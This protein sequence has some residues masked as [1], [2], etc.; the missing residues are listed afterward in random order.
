MQRLKYFLNFVSII[1]FFTVISFLEDFSLFLGV[2]FTFLHIILIFQY[3]CKRNCDLFSPIILY[4]L[5]NILVPLSELYLLFTFNEN[6]FLNA[7]SLSKDFNYLFNLT[8]G[9]NLGAYIFCLIGHKI[10]CKIRINP[11]SFQMPK[12]DYLMIIKFFIFLGLLNFFYNQFYVCSFNFTSIASLYLNVDVIE[13]NSST[14][15]YNLIYLSLYIYLTCINYDKKKKNILLFLCVI[16]AFTT[17]RLFFTL[18]IILVTIAYSYETNESNNKN[19]KFLLLLFLLALL[20]ITLYIIRVSFTYSLQDL[21]FSITDFFKQ[22]GYYA[23]NKGNTPNIAI[24]M[25]L[26]DKWTDFL[27]GKSFLSP[28][29]YFF[30]KSIDFTEFIPAA[31]MKKYYFMA[32]PSGNLPVTGV[33]ELFMNFGYFGVFIGMFIFGGVLRIFYNLFFFSKNNFIKLLGC[34]YSISFFML[35]SKGEVNNIDLFILFEFISFIIFVE[36]LCIAIKN[37]VKRGCL[38]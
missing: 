27:Y 34:Y 38:C 19:K 14:L 28:L 32:V 24:Q 31:L 37:N 4:S 25:E 5:Y 10:F 3:V 18:T 33:G 35:F 7:V 20:G 16:I 15:L 2:I 36:F 23:F 30:R 26:Y 9:I 12:I 8:C 17:L 1:S 29:L 11:I 13:Q 22:F 21:D 6:I